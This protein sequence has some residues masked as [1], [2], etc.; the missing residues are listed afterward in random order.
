M[1]RQ[2]EHDDAENGGTNNPGT[3]GE[4]RDILGKD[5]QDLTAEDL[6]GDGRTEGD[7]SDLPDAETKHL[8]DFA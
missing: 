3:N 2:A 7:S 1:T 6:E 8:G 4:D 5:Q